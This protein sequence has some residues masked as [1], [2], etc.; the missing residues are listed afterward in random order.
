M[1]S[2][3]E[4]DDKSDQDGSIMQPKSKKSIHMLDDDEDS[5]VS[6][7]QSEDGDDEEDV[8]ER[9]EELM[10][11]DPKALKNKI[12]SEVRQILKYMFMI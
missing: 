10:N 2:D 7:E 11:L 12:A 4:E 1:E 5:D 3:P 6:Q 9:D 8:S